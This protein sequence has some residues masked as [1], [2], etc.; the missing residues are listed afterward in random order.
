MSNGA[1]DLGGQ[2]LAYPSVPNTYPNS[3]IVCLAPGP[4]LTKQD[5]YLVRDA[6]LPAITVNDAFMFARWAPVRYA[7][8]GYWWSNSPDAHTDYPGQMFTLEYGAP[9]K[10]VKLGYKSSAI[11]SNDPTWLATGGHSGY[12]AV[13]L[14]FLMGARVILLL[15]YDMQVGKNGMHHAGGDRV[16]QKHPRYELWIG[17][18]AGLRAALD[19]Y[20]VLLFN[21]SRS[22]ALDIARA[23]LEAGLLYG[24]SL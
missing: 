21:C 15:G 9:R 23:P 20:G 17:R 1:R 24:K 4:S 13:N 3:T 18:Y 12:A 5:A 6:G 7:S 11:L 2:P 19:D 22:S 14:A 10:V 8:D 16:G